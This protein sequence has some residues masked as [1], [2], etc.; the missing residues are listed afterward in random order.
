MGLHY[1]PRLSQQ[2]RLPVPTMV[3]RQERWG[4]RLMSSGLS[5]EL[6]Q[7]QLILT[8]LH[9]LHLHTHTNHHQPHSDINQQHISILQQ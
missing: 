9:L 6:L 4:L 2:R 1:Q 3:S 8:L 7:S 5:T